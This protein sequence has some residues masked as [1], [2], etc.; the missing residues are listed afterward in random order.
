MCCLKLRLV[1][2][3]RWHLLISVGCF[4]LYLQHVLTIVRI[5][6]G[7]HPGSTSLWVTSLCRRFCVAGSALFLLIGGLCHEEAPPF[8][9]LSH[10]RWIPPRL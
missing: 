4:R 8:D 6:V 5:S 3:E 1:P 9:G 7:Y 10:V 2:C